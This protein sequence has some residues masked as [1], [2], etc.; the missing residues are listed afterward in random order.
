[1]SR[2]EKFGLFVFYALLSPLLI[3]YF[4]DRETWDYL[5]PYASACG[6]AVFFVGC[7]SGLA[8]LVIGLIV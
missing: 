7:L 5:K 1:M 2:F 8:F 3:L 6:L 4:T